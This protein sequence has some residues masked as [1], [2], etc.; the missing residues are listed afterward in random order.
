MKRIFAT[1]G[2]V[3][4][5]LT[6]GTVRAA[7]KDSPNEPEYTGSQIMKMAREAHTAEQYTVL[8]DYYAVRQRI[9]KRKA[10]QEMHLWA[11]RS[12]MNNPLRGKWPRPVD[13]ARNLYEYYEYQIAQSAG[14]FAK[15]DRLADAAA[16]K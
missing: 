4:F 16:A 13:S 2:I 6:A 14:S 7:Q 12:E 9:F 10:A 8:A 5:A 11:L 15:Y 3:I 1:I